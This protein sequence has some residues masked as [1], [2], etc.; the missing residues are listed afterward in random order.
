MPLTNF[1]N[2]VSSFG[3]PIVS[4]GL[5]IPT[6]IRNGNAWF[7]DGVYG[8][9]GNPG[10][11]VE[12]PFFTIQRAID[13]AQAGDTIFVFPGSY[14]ENLTVETDYLTLIGAQQAGYAR[15]DVVPSSGVALVVTAQGFQALHMRF[16]VENNDC[17]QQRGNGFF[18]T[19]CVFDGNATA[20]KGFRLLPSDTD[21]SYTA[22]EGLILAN[23]F[24][25][26][27]NNLIFDTGAAPAVGVGST[28]NKIINNVF[29]ASTIDIVTAD[30]G[31]ALYS[32]KTALIQG[33]QFV[34]K[35]KNCYIDL[36]TT[37]GGAAG[38][39]NGAINGNY[40]ASDVITAN[41]T[42]KMQGTGFTFTGNLYTVGIKDGSGLD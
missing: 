32:V 39:Q 15:P 7:V 35:N 14:D 2:G 13:V 18:Y 5:S 17:V 42:V 38:D 8:S 1:G 21:D 36:T 27:A 3:Q 4:T 25:G 33:N 30:T 9:D 10:S 11:I 20:S 41:V 28:D 37:N 31:A 16:A 34:D 23:L 29:Q 12:A 40:F 19:D 24:R 26:N 6:L 22:S